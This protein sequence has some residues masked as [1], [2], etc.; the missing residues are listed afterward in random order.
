[1]GKRIELT[2]IYRPDARIARKSPT[3]SAPQPQAVVASKTYPVKG[4]KGQT[5]KPAKARSSVVEL[6][7][8]NGLV[9][10]SNPAAPTKFIPATDE[11]NAILI[12]AHKREVKAAQMRRYRAN[13]KLK[14]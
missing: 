8:H 3:A 7:A 1:M 6:A 10:G 13:R 14:K 12:L 9:A 5:K 11:K 4:R 2:E